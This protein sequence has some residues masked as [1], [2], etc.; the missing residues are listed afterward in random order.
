M[1]CES[2]LH[3]K[4]QYKLNLNVKLKSLSYVFDFNSSQ[5]NRKLK[6]TNQ[7]PKS[8]IF[9]ILI[10]WITANVYF[11]LLIYLYWSETNFSFYFSMFLAWAVSIYLLSAVEFR[12][13]LHTY[14]VLFIDIL[15]NQWKIINCT[16]WHDIVNKVLYKLTFHFNVE[17][18]HNQQWKKPQYT[19]SNFTGFSRL[20]IF[21]ILFSSGKKV[22]EKRKRNKNK[23]IIIIPIINT[24]TWWNVISA[25]TFFR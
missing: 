13:V 20:K 25:K 5:T 10:K 21:S 17:K 12:F 18:Q 3:R 9:S 14:Y 15:H 19:Y 2:F 1:K 8:T 7:Q 4:C 16:A 11:M 23:Q 24:C 6:K 22:D